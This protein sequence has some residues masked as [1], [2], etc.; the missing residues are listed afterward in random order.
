MKKLIVCFVI[1]I[2][3]F[4]GCTAH[5]DPAIMS[6]N[7]STLAG[8]GEEV[9]V[10]PDGRKVIRFQLEMGSHYHD[11]WIYVVEGSPTVTV[12]RTESH[13]KSSSNHADVIIDGVN[14]TPA[15]QP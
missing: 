1:A 5:N 8:S 6:I 4:A 11:H 12:N 3:L 7:K 2:S 14:Y 9:G 13:G 15:E 10:L